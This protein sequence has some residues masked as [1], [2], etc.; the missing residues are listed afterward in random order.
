MA[1]NVNSITLTESV[2][3]R[4]LQTEYPEKKSKDDSMS[5]GYTL[6][7]R[8]IIVFIL[9]HIGSFYGLYLC[10][11]GREYFLYGYGIFLFLSILITKY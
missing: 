1:P 3:D 6:V 2:K 11:T 10:I 9:L 7:W 4:N 5:G 8:N